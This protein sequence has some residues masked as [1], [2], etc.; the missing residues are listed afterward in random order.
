MK[1]LKYIGIFILFFVV[2]IGIVLLIA[3]KQLEYTTETTIDAPQGKVWASLTD[4]EQMGKW[5]E[6]YKGTKHIS[7]EMGMAGSVSEMT[8]T[9]NGNEF[10]M[11]ERIHQVVSGESMQFTVT[12]PEV[13]EMDIDIKLEALNKDRTKLTSHSIAKPLRTMM[14]LFM[15]SDKSYVQKDK[16]DFERFKKWVE[17]MD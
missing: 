15:F 10:V 9:E 14:R 2:A 17:S 4:T 6:G 11:E 8:L 13:L 12:L 1:A 3:P 16:E 5:M 7:G